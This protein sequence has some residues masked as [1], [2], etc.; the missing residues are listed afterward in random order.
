MAIR[1][2]ASGFRA[3]GNWDHWTVVVPALVSGTQ[4]LINVPADK[5]LDLVGFRIAAYFAASAGN[6]SP[7]VVSLYEG[8]TGSTALV[9]LF[10]AEPAAYAGLSFSESQD[11]GDGL[12]L[13]QG[14][15][16]KI[17]IPPNVGFGTGPLVITAMIYGRLN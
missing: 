1:T 14:N 8:S 4:M 13:Q 15:D 3:S 12:R 2:R 5:S 17:G 6:T 7:A 10:I 11:L 9:P 16:L